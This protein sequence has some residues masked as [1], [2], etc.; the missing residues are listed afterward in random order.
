M[1]I[2]VLH[3]DQTRNGIEE[4]ERKDTTPYL[5]TLRLICF[6]FSLLFALAVPFLLCLSYR[7]VLRTLLHHKEEEEDEEEEDEE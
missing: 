5:C 3:V 6:E 2:R 1:S 4:E 7:A